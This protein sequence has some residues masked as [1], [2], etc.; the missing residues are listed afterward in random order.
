MYF[1]PAPALPPQHSLV[2]L[3]LAAAIGVS[4]LAYGQPAPMPS[5]PSPLSQNPTTAPPEGWVFFDD[6]VAADLKLSEEELRQVRAVDDSYNREYIAL[7]T[8][9]VQSVEYKELTDRRNTDLK[10]ILKPKTYAAWNRKY[11]TRHPG[12]A[13]TDNRTHSHDRPQEPRRETREADH[14]HTPEH[15]ARAPE[16]RPAGGTGVPRRPLPRRPS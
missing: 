14:H 4:A 12:P 5:L 6:A 15:A 8:A 13:P 9:P 1:T 11:A 7:G 10:R 2:V 3:L 16:Q